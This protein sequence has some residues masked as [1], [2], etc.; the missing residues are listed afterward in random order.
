VAALVMAPWVIRNYEISGKFVPTMTIGGLAMFQ[1]EETVRNMGNGKDSKDLLDD[2]G[3]EQIR[4]GHEMGLRMREDFFPQF[5]SANDEIT[6]YRELGHRAWAEYAAQPSLLAR[7]IFHNTWAFWLE[8]RTAKATL[9]NASFMVPFLLLAIHGAWTMVRRERKA[10]ILV[11][12]IV[13]YVLPHLII[14][15]VARYASSLI[16]VLSILVACSVF[17]LTS[18][19]LVPRKSV[20][21]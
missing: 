8:G 11:I 7:A 17:S 2:A 3:K 20:A 19:L 1:G 16:P 18:R 5:Y 15:S 6:F 21:A 10:W 12:A 9:L 14:I 13:V 4:I